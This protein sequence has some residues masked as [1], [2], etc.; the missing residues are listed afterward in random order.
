M[1]IK[2]LAGRAKE[3]GYPAVTITDP[4]GIEN[5]HPYLRG[6]DQGALVQP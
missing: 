2:D 3:F 5:K 6:M 4:Y 1:K